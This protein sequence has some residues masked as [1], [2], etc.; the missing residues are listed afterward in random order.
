MNFDYGYKFFKNAK[1]QHEHQENFVLLEIR[2]K[3][4]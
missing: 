4:E 1:H 2:N 3:V